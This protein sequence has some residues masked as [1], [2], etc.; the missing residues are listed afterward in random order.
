M[1]VAFFVII[2]VCFFISAA[3][4]EPSFLLDPDATKVKV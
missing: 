1:G 3:Q 2:V 4:R